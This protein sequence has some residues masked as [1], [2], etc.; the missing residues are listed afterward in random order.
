M[1]CWDFLGFLLSEIYNPNENEDDYDDSDCDSDHDKDDHELEKQLQTEGWFESAI[2]IKDSI[3]LDVARSSYDWAEARGFISVETNEIQSEDNLVEVCLDSNEEK[4]PR[5]DFVQWQNMLVNFPST[6]P[7]DGEVFVVFGDKKSLSENDL[8][9]FSKENVIRC[10]GQRCSYISYLIN[11]EKARYKNSFLLVY[12]DDSEQN[13][14]TRFTRILCDDRP[15]CLIWA[16]ELNTFDWKEVHENQKMMELGEHVN[17]THD[18][19]QFYAKHRFLVFAL[20]DEKN[21]SDQRVDVIVVN[22]NCAWAKYKTL[23]LHEISPIKKRF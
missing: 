20:S 10:N 1:S 6:F 4:R 12:R 15:V 22:E 13:P 7:T 14:L 23:V 21:P 8:N 9:S 18:N 3:L 16:K 5:H 11:E 17:Y 19:K 2:H